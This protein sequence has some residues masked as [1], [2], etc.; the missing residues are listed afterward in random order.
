MLRA[1]YAFDLSF[2][3]LSS[4]YL[5]REIR[6]AQRLVRGSRLYFNI[7]FLSYKRDGIIYVPTIAG[8]GCHPLAT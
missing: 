6:E 5:R 8:K 7:H 4:E 1:K 2:E 3:E